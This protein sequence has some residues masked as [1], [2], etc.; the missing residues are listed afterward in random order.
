MNTDGGGPLY[1]EYEYRSSDPNHTASYLQQSVL[2]VVKSLVPPG[3]SILDAGCGNGWFSQ[4]LSDS[5]FNVSAVDM[6]R[7]G[8]E[9][10]RNA[11]LPIDFRV[12]S[13]YDDLAEVFGRKFDAVISLEVIEHLYDPRLF[14]RRMADVL[15][16]GRVLILS[17]PYHGY[18]KNLALAVSGKLDAHFTALW[19]GGH[20]KFWSPR[21][22]SILLQTEGFR[23]IGVKGAGRLPY[24]WKSM[25]VIAEK[26][27]SPGAQR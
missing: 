11:Q 4:R 13:V 9:R 12:A 24:L 22:I 18:L 27:P 5:G 20:I 3:A 6:S 8:I 19:D 25:I 2:G 17:T 21:T 14:V 16:D 1:K 15:G 10:A 7:S 23:V 26:V